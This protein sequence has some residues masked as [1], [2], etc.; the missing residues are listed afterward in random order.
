MCYT[1]VLNRLK[2]KSQS[3][4]YFLSTLFSIY[5]LTNCQIVMHEG[6]EI[7]INK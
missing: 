2:K 5:I 6:R 3:K 4:K 1:F 7:N